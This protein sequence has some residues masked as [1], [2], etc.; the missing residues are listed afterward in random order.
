M[1]SL[2]QLKQSIAPVYKS[3]LIV[4]LNRINALLRPAL[5]TITWGALNV[6]TFIDTFHKVVSDLTFLVSHA[7]KLLDN[8]IEKRLLEIGDTCILSPLEKIQVV[9]TDE[10]CSIMEEA[11]RNG[12]H[13]LEDH[14]ILIESAVEQLICT[15]CPWL[16]QQTEDDIFSQVTFVQQELVEL[17][18]QDPSSILKESVLTHPSV[19]K[20]SNANDYIEFFDH[21]MVTKFLPSI[22]DPQ[23]FSLTENEKNKL[24]IQIQEFRVYYRERTYNAIV[25]CIRD[26]LKHLRR[27]VSRCNSDGFFITHQPIF[28]A[29]VELCIPN[30]SMNPSLED[31]QDCINRVARN[32]I[33][34]T[35]RILL[36][37]QNR[38]LPSNELA[39]LYPALGRR[40]DIAKVVFQLTGAFAAMRSRVQQYLMSFHKYDFLWREDKTDAINVF[41][42]DE[43]TLDD[44]EREIQRYHE[45]EIEITSIHPVRC[46]ES[47]SLSSTSLKYSLRT[48]AAAWKNRLGGAVHDW[49]QSEL[50]S[51]YTFM[52]D[53]TRELVRE[54]HDL[55]DLKIIMDTLSRLRD[56]ESEIDLKMAP[57]LDAYSLLRR[58]EVAIPE[59][60]LETVEVLQKNWRQLKRL[61]EDTSLKLLQIQPRFKAQLLASLNQ[62]DIDLSE[63]KSEYATRGPSIYGVPLKIAK[64]RLSEYS[65]RLDVFKERTKL[66]A[67]GQ[68]LFGLPQV[69]YP[70]LIEL[71]KEISQLNALYKLHSDI[72][73]SISSLSNSFW[74]QLD[75]GHVEQQ[76]TQ[77]R[78]QYSCL[79]KSVHRF[80]AYSQMVSSVDSILQII[81]TITQ[82]SHKSMR[83][84]HWQRLGEILNV[85]LDTSPDVFKLHVLLD[86]PLLDHREEIEEMCAS[87]V[88]E[89]EIEAKLEKIKEE[90][91]FQEFHFVQ[92]IDP[93]SIMLDSRHVS[94][95]LVR[96]E[97]SLTI[98]ATLM[99]NRYN[100]PFRDSI[101]DWIQRLSAVQDMVE[102]WLYVQSLWQYL[103]AVFSGGD[104]A[105][106]LPFEAKRFNI[107]D[108]AWN[109][110]MSLVASSPNVF[111][112][113]QADGPLPSVL[114]FLVSQLELTQRR[115]T[116]Y[117]DTKRMAFPR[118]CFVSDRVLLEIL[119]KGTQPAQLEAHLLGVFDSIKRLE[120]DPLKQNVVVGI[121]SPQGEY[122]PFIQPVDT[123][124]KPI[125]EWLSAIK[126]EMQHT[127]RFLIG[128]AIDSIVTLPIEQFLRQC[129][130]QSCLVA[131]HVLWTHDCTIGLD[132]TMRDK[133]AMQNVLRNVDTFL[134]SLVQ[135]A[136]RQFSD[137]MER[138]KIETLIT[139]QV[140]QRDTVAHFVRART[141]G[142]TDFDWM[143][144]VRCYWRSANRLNLR[145]P[146]T[147]FHD[148]LIEIVDVCIKYSYEYLGCQERLVRTPLTDRCYITLAQALRLSMG[149]A[150]Q[151]PAGTGKT[152]TVKDLGKTLGKFV[153]VFNCSDTM[154]VGGLGRIIKGLAQ[155]GTWGD[156]DEFNRIRVEVLSVVAQQISAVFGAMKERR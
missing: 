35:R 104:I 112:V 18:I 116:G 17:D 90:W 97:D 44:F 100:E 60:E 143:K 131:L 67:I 98:L 61:G 92:R 22:I 138:T 78:Q 129:N 77:L 114:P 38:N 86:A 66:L 115:L 41:L 71:T 75:F 81:P 110:V 156:F 109:K 102:R 70:I 106:Q 139:V 151:G 30:I 91:L 36:W 80:E 69:K 52:Q 103:G 10:F 53:I 21:T 72:V 85:D 119:G 54:P 137:S 147:Q 23:Q 144:Q 95:L 15:L 117:L 46:I 141:R 125:E 64:E 128:K 25:C 59:E 108:K 51:V 153:V 134:N 49:A 148:C 145:Q 1:L 5:T 27:R 24:N 34:S 42:D 68:Q 126:V 45:L 150:P 63:L 14:S 152:E 37:N 76:L 89:A 56:L 13:F 154:D 127:V 120:F 16:Q 57:V 140:H 123:Q 133:N 19:E 73:S 87:A 149:G 4:H 74:V 132:L 3:L 31:I 48:E 43:P 130:A 93:V 29:D 62:F 65:R 122:T 28:K 142:T 6:R 136:R 58:Y 50:D 94:D 96:L 2:R 11:I 111:K 83:R 135:Q 124:Q 47:I 39:S 9:T 55:D 20:S 105:R 101:A 88:K 8:Q 40:R 146:G 99:S 26:A 107:N 118:F 7:N 79:P 155:S 84:R 82:L 121:T 32:V 12:V 113:S 33:L